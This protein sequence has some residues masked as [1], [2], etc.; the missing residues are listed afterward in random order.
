MWSELLDWTFHWIL[1]FLAFE[2]GKR[3][4]EKDVAHSISLLLESKSTRQSEFVTTDKI[5]KDLEPKRCVNCNGTRAD[6]A[7][8]SPSSGAPSPEGRERRRLSRPVSL[9]SDGSNGELRPLMIADILSVSKE[10]ESENY[11]TEVVGSP[12]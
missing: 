2:L 7:L 5:S 11:G 10:S 8:T 4:N 6:G 3:W 12:C 1:L 9:L